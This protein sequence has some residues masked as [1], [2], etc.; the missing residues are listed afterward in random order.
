MLYFAFIIFVNIMLPQ[1]SNNQLR[2]LRDNFEIWLGYHVWNYIFIQFHIDLTYL[3]FLDAFLVDIWNLCCCDISLNWQKKK[4][5]VPRHCMAE[6]IP[7]DAY[8]KNKELHP[9]FCA[10]TWRSID[11]SYLVK[12]L[13]LFFNYIN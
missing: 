6:T 13:P 8:K 2:T 3:V 1:R 7:M 11:S 10:G 9:D 4:K 5:V 12:A